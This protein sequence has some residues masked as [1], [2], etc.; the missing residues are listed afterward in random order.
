M[1]NL[2]IIIVIFLSACHRDTEFAIQP[3][4]KPYYGAF[5]ASAVKH[6]FTR[7]DEIDNL[8]MIIRPNVL[9][10]YNAWGVSRK[11][12][13]GQHYI[14]IDQNFYREHPTWIEET[15]YHELGHCYLDQVHNG[16]YSI[17]NPTINGWP[18]TSG[19]KD[20]LI[21]DLFYSISH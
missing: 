6:H 3:E 12:P 14:Y 21:N 15:V 7:F 17:M 13:G 16:S 19:S 18:E 1:K 2:L 8:I 20:L 4:L 9:R 11:I 10:D 5:M